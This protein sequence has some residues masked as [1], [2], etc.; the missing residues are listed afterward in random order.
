MTARFIPAALVFV[1]LGAC[2]VQTPAPLE[3][4]TATPVRP[5]DTLPAGFDRALV[6]QDLLATAAGRF[7]AAALNAALAA[8][9]HLIVKRFAGMAP[10]PPPG[11]GAD[12]R[13]PTPSA[14]LMRQRAGWSVATPAGWRPVSASSAAELDAILAGPEF[15]SEPAYT[16]PCPD[17]GASLLLL[18]I[19]GRA[20]TVRNSTC[21]SQASRLVEAALR[22]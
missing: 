21:N 11:S 4:A 1:G 16:P 3:P 14:I 13:A 6:R 7:G 5:L 19:P 20:E 2:A 18:K 17:F 8:P 9:A 15:W 10:P 12:W 22:A